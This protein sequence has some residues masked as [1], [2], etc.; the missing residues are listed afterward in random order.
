MK[1]FSVKKAEIAM[2]KSSSD[3][4]SHPKNSL[5]LTPLTIKEL[6]PNIEKATNI[7]PKQYASRKA[8]APRLSI[9]ASHHHPDLP[10][11]C[12]LSSRCK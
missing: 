4:R 10:F 8:E 2:P 7:A 9:H 1:M 6:A 11:K 5:S 3:T 12:I